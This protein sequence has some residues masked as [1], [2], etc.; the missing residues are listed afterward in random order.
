MRAAIDAN[1]GTAKW[2][3]L[4]IV[5][6]LMVHAY[7]LDPDAPLQPPALRLETGVRFGSGLVRA[8]R[9]HVQAR[10]SQRQKFMEAYATTN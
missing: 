1:A 4:T 2:G 3:M 7:W 9:A 10:R 5:R 8:A 6:P